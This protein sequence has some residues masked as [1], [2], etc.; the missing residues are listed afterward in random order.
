MNIHIILFGLPQLDSSICCHFGISSGQRVFHHRGL[1]K[2][3]GAPRHARRCG[4]SLRIFLEGSR[5]SIPSQDFCFPNKSV[6][7]CSIRKSDMKIGLNGALVGALGAPLPPFCMKNRS[8][9]N[10]TA[11]RPQKIYKNI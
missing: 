8:G 7:I 10:G 5:R 1:E 11:P 3:W 4:I 6:S 9:S 2:L